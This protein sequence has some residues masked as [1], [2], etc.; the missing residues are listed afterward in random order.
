MSS[1]AYN[2][3]AM[4]GSEGAAHAANVARSAQRRDVVGKR[5]LRLCG[6]RRRM[7]KRNK[8]LYKC[9]LGS[10]HP[11]PSARPGGRLEVKINGRF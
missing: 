5:W 8:Y 6:A 2:G 3:T 11:T 1:V 10:E 4:E 7:G 9:H